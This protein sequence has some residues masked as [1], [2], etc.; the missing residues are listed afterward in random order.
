MEGIALS[1]TDVSKSY[2]NLK[3]LDRIGFH[4]GKGEIFALIGPNG[5]G[6]TTALRII[7]TIL[8]P[9]A[10]QVLIGET[11][12]VRSAEKGISSLIVLAPP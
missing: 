6:K 12:A 4:V 5:A 1:V 11:D 9:D 10:G 7:A 3:A 8:K 2:G